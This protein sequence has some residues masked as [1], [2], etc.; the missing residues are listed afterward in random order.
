MG[1]K[2]WN[3]AGGLEGLVSVSNIACL[4]VSRYN[5]DVGGLDVRLLALLI[6]SIADKVLA[7]GRIVP[8]DPLRRD[9]VRA[10]GRSLDRDGQHDGGNEA[11][12]KGDGDGD[13]K[14]SSCPLAD[15]RPGPAKGRDG[16][17]KL[18]ERCRR[19]RLDVH[20]HRELV[21]EAGPL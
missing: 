10:L 8:L 19:F 20:V 2:G 12:K 18:T 21:L 16:L 11:D 5:G 4:K 1:V 13:D 14:K 6:V 9:V 15:A 7:K 3:L 17:W